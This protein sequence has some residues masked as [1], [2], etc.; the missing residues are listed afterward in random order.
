MSLGVTLDWHV[1]LF[2]C[3]RLPG[4]EDTHDYIY[5]Y[6]SMTYKRKLVYIAFLSDMHC[7]NMPVAALVVK[8]PTAFTVCNDAMR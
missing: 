4:T 1:C 6:G 3:V 2:R 5:F 8:E 7:E